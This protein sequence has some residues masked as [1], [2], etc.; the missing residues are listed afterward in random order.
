[1]KEPLTESQQ[2]MVEKNMG[3]IGAFIRRYPPPRFVTM[4]DYH[5]ELSH[6]LCQAAQSWREGGAQFSTWAFH[7]FMGSRAKIIRS[8]SG[9]AKRERQPHEEMGLAQAPDPKSE[10]PEKILSPE[11]EE[12]IREVF[13]SLGPDEQDMLT[14]STSREMGAR[15]GITHQAAQGRK[16]KLM[17][18]LRGKMASIFPYEWRRE[19]GFFRAGFDPSAMIQVE[20]ET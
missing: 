13:F 15:L 1:M 6:G 18:I 5:G 20:D 16:N 17:A 2:E 10:A 14:G 3:L 4:D 7:Q 11:Q 9:P 8:H 19:N 12:Y